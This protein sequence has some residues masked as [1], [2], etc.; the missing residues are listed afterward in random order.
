[1]KIL[2]TG[3]FGVAPNEE[4]TITVKKS[5]APYA[6]SFSDIN[7]AAWKSTFRPDPLSEIRTFDSPATDGSRATVTIVF[8]F[9]PDAAGAF[10]PTDQYSVEIKGSMGGD[11]R[12]TTI[13]PPPIVS[14]TYAFIVGAA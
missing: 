4:I 8:D 11:V 13:V 5:L 14:R 1:M 9:A 7:G 12:T 6:A 2:A 10:D 3:D